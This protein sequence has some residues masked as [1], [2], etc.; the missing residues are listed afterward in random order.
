M[1]DQ[2]HKFVSV[3]GARVLCIAL[4]AV[5]SVALIGL[6]VQSPQ[7]LLPNLL[8]ATYWLLSLGVGGLAFIAMHYVS[9][10]RW[11]TAIRRV[12]EAMA[13][14]I[15]FAAV[16]LALVLVAGRSLYPWAADTAAIENSLQKAWLNWPFFLGRSVVYLGLWA[17]FGALILRHSRR[18]DVDA[19]IAHTV[20]N[21]RLSAA[22]LVVFGLTLWLASEDW[23][24]SMEPG[25]SST[26]FCVYQFAGIVV[27]GLAGSILFSVWLHGVGLFRRVLT[28]DHL[29][30]LGMLLFGFTTF[31]VYLWFCQYMLIWYVN[32][33]EE[34]PWIAARSH[35]GWAR[36]LTASLV[37]NWAIP[38]VVLL[39]RWTKKRPAILGSIAALL[40]VGRWLDLYVTI[41]PF[42][43]FPT[44]PVMSCELGVLAA[45]TGLF[46]LLFVLM[47]GK[48]AIVPMGDPYLLNQ[49]S[50]ALQDDKEVHESAT[51]RDAALS[52]R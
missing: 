33:P 50:Q 35:G 28:T 21:V 27:A 14:T 40:L 25:W 49:E 48:A 34:T 29:H 2:E 18:Q 19:D 39:P 5:G 42:S 37:L 32:N 8:L 7:R 16:G 10:G 20:S 46:G 45:A 38:F 12:P 30:D 17:L 44:V 15:P 36:L 13:A 41:M 47:M 4:I 9:G 22:F 6:L 3:R 31:W 52:S 26:V 51:V 43:G 11:A 23:L 1:N 24:M